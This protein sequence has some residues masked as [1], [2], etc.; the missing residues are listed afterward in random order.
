MSAACAEI[1]HSIQKRAY[2]QRLGLRE[3]QWPIPVWVRWKIISLLG[4]HVV[5][6][7]HILISEWIRWN[8]VLLHWLHSH[9]DYTTH[10]APCEN[11]TSPPSTLRSQHTT[12]QF[13]CDSD[14]WEH[15]TKQNVVWAPYRPDPVFVQYHSVCVYKSHQ[16]AS[17]SCVCPVPQCLCLQISSECQSISSTCISLYITSHMPQSQRSLGHYWKD[18]NHL[19]PFLPLSN[20]QKHLQS[21]RPVHSLMLSSHLFVCLSFCLLA[22]FLADLIWQ[23]P[24]SCYMTIRSY[25]SYFHS[26]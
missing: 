6:A 11:S 15:L 13:L 17:L 3:N 5:W 4:Q 23:A 8:R 9:F 1:S 10:Q 22:L 21:G 24:L 26:G 12:Y 25:F 16:N 7:Y 19:P 2:H 18:C 20:A 14:E